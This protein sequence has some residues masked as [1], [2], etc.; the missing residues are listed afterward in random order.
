MKAERVE[1]SYSSLPVPKE[2]FKRA[3]ERLFTRA[4]SNSRMYKSF[5]LKEVYVRKK[6]LPM[7]IMRQ[8]KIMPREVVDACIGLTLAGCQVPTKV[9]P[10]FPSLTGQRNSS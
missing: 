7:R 1:R 9:A 3:K 10:S 4:C 2:G 5:N 8:W 6:F